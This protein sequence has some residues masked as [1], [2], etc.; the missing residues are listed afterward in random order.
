[1]AG[2]QRNGVSSCMLAQ[3]IAR[4]SGELQVEGADAHAARAQVFGEDAADLAVADEADA[5]IRVS[6]H[7][8]EFRS[9]DVLQAGRLQRLAHLVHV[10]AQHAGRELGALLA[11]VGLARLGRIGHLLRYRGGNDDHAVVVGH[12][13]VARVDQ[14]AGADHRD[15]DRAERRLDRALGA[16]RAAPHRELHRRSGP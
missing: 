9:V 14:R 12:D 16:D 5:F 11:F 2:R 15:V 6:I 1:M 3:R 10:E 7:H 13:H 4:C 8:C